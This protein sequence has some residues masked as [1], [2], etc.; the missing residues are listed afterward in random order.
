MLIKFCCCPGKHSPL[1]PPPAVILVVFIYG[2]EMKSIR[3]NPWDFPLSRV[4]CFPQLGAD[5]SATV[6]ASTFSAFG[7]TSTMAS[8]FPPF[9][10]DKKS[11]SP[12]SI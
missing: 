9:F 1:M 2:P 10:I 8:F 12:V 6:K 5:R 7:T 3:M 4:T 11:K